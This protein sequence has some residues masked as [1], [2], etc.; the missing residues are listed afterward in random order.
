VVWAVTHSR[1]LGCMSGPGRE[2]CRRSDVLAATVSNIG[3]G[4]ASAA[5]WSAGDLSA[6]G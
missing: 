1:E 4:N 3:D 6:L 2:S 5:A